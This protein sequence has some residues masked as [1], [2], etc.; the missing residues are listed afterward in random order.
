MEARQDELTARMAAHFQA[1][2]RLRDGARDNPRAAPG[3]TKL[4]KHHTRR[5]AALSAI[6]CEGPRLPARETTQ[7]KAS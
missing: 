4:A 2:R 1:A 3:L 7:L 6:I 5:V